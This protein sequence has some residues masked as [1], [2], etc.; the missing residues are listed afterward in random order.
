MKDRIKELR[1]DVDNTAQ[2]IKSLYS[3]DEIESSSKSLFFAK[4]WM[5]KLLGGLGNPSP[6]T[7]DGKRESIA[8][9]EPTAEK[10]LT[11]KFPDGFDD[12]D[13]VQKIDI[14]RQE[15]AKIIKRTEGMQFG[16][17]RKMN[18]AKENV[19]THLC[20]ARFWLGFELER[21]REEDS[22]E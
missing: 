1:F 8:D 4:A 11:V 7:N 14:L 5:G 3:S 17:G 21:L 22:N 9:V 18:L 16:G 12:F 20:E 15:I 2:V 13:R 10:M 6:Y 19:Y